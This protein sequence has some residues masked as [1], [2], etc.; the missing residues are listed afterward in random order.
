MS[1]NSSLAFRHASV[2]A[3]S[4]QMDE[5]W[6][7]RRMNSN[8]TGSRSRGQIGM[9]PF[10]SVVLIVSSEKEFP[11][12]VDSVCCAEKTLKGWWSFGGSEKRLKSLQSE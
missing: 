4:Q 5:A 9:K 8:T 12:N 3:Q 6:A 1:R 7:F 2:L 11:R 10:V